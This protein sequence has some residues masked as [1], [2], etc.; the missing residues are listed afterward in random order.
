MIDMDDSSQSD[1]SPCRTPRAVNAHR[2][3]Q[4]QRQTVSHGNTHIPPPSSNSPE[5]LI[6]WA[7]FQRTGDYTFSTVPQAWRWR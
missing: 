5:L 3:A 4:I 7:A 1:F 2:Q 6:T